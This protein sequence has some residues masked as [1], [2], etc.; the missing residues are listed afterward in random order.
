MAS[1]SHFIDK[2]VSKLNRLDAENLQAQFLS[3][4]RERGILETIFHLHT[5]V[6]LKLM[7]G[8]LLIL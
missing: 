2:L 4:A 1:Q 6:W 5:L 7:I 3:L 8:N